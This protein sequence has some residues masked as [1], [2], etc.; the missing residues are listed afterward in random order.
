MCVLCVCVCV[1]VCVCGCECEC[2]F[3]CVRVRVRVCVR[4]CM[5][6]C[7]R[8]CVCVCVCVCVFV[9]RVRACESDV[10]V[11]VCHTEHVE[12]AAQRGIAQRRPASPGHTPAAQASA[13]CAPAAARR[14]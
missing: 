3:V 2:V 8:V 10:S 12:R 11:N 14:R 7:V 6:A 13:V 9:A 4:A 1:C 5:R